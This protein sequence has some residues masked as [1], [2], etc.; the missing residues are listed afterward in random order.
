MA[1]GGTGVG[2]SPDGS[3]QGAGDVAGAPDGID[4]EGVTRWLEE[5][6][7]LLGPLDVEVIQGGRSNLTYRVTDPAG[8][9]V[10]LRRPPLHGVI[11][12]A[13]DM[14]REHRII[15]ALAA[16]EVPVPPVVGFEPEADVTGAPFYVMRFVDGAVLRDQETAE[17][18][19]DDAAR[20]TAGLDL[21]DVLVRLHA[22]DPDEVGLGDL[23]RKQDYLARQLRRWHG[24]LEKARTRELPLLDEVHARLVAD[25]PDQGPAAIVHGDYRLDN[26]IVDP[27]DGKVRAVLDWEL[28]TLGD[29]LADLGLLQC[30]WSQPGDPTQP[31]P[32]APTLAAGFPARQDLVERYA[33]G[34]GRDVSQLPYYV[35][36][37]YWKLACILEGV[38]ARFA[39]GAYGET[40]DSFEH[41]GR[42]VVELGERAAEA[43][44]EAG[45]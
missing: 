38:Y 16:T 5:R 33:A 43:A 39:S 11:E 21:V 36:F 44:T 1:T 20:R 27:A 8:R 14:G 35:A 25:I 22:V 31:L 34:S 24:Q 4:V 40:D 17:Q 18:A 9:Q 3:R 28:T 7:E 6:T 26:L 29:P 10:I 12:S 32:G 19:V 41:F 2:G 15:A 13:H 42:V 23:G 45:R 30:Y 37:G